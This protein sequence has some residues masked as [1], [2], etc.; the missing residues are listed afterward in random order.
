[1]TW[2]GVVVLLVGIALIFLRS[3]AID[4]VVMV[5]GGMFLLAAAINLYF[6]FSSTKVVVESN[7]KTRSHSGLSI[8]SM[9]SA[10][11][12]AALGLWMLLDPATM[13]SLVVYVFAALMI[14][15][16]IYH[17]CVLVF[18]FKPVKFP[19]IFYVLPTL[20][21]LCGIV[22]LIIGA[23]ATKDYIVL[24]TGIC[25]IVYAVCCF[26]E[27]AGASSFYKQKQLTE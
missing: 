18:S 13:S 15:S 26:L 24:I 9:L 11:A 1:M 21:A 16:G 10:I 22:I 27:V 20:L 3:T 5:L 12:A 17:V 4:V 23:S 8:G 14:I 7:G 25:M 2:T 6:L 19:A